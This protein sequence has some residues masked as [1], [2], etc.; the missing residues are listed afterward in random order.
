MRHNVLQGAK[1]YVTEWDGTRSVVKVRNVGQGARTV[2]RC[3]DSTPHLRRGG[4]VLMQYEDGVTHRVTA[5]YF[6][7]LQPSVAAEFLDYW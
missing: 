1:Y 5:R 4:D 3:A 2:S 7:S 6:Q